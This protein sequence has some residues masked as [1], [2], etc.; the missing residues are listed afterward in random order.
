VPDKPAEAKGATPGRDPS[1]AFVNL[2]ELFQ[3]APEAKQAATKVEEQ[4]AA[5][6]KE[7]NS[8]VTDFQKQQAELAGM[9][10][11]LAAMKPDD[12]GRAQLEQERQAKVD[13]QLTR[14]REINEYRQQQEREV[15][16]KTATLRDPLLAD[17][18]GAAGRV[19]QNVNFLIDVS[20]RSLSGIPFVVLH[21]PTANVTQRLAPAL[22][23]KDPSSV[24][25]ARNLKVGIVDMNK[26][27]TQLKRTKEAEGKLIAARTAAQQENDRRETALK[28]ERAKADTLT[29][30][31]KEKQASKT[32]MLEAELNDFRTK[33]STELSQQMVNAGQPILADMAAAL[34]RMAGDQIALVFDSTGMSA[35]G[36]TFLIWSKDIPDFSADLTAMLNGDAKTSKTEGAPSNNLRFGLL[37]LERA[38]TAMPDAK[39][40]EAEIAEAMQRTAAELGSANAQTRAEKQQQLQNLARSKRQAVLSKI[41]AAANNIAVA[42]QFNAI[43]DSGGKT[44]GNTPAIIATHDVPDLTDEVIAKASAPAP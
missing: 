9:N 22:Q 39:K 15:Q 31:E 30:A 4:K 20:G 41:T 44:V 40:A 1:F 7:Y 2:D 8:R 3:N 36:T 24:N 6:E 42:G 21:P 14:E 5:V 33:K 17:V 27:F 16:Q 11:R 19:A 43:F 18:R 12:P 35:S 10:Q 29:G 32:R 34:S 37:D 25:S 23:G 38:Y 28:E 26:V 13:Q